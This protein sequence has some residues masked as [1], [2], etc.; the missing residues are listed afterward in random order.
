MSMVTAPFITGALTKLRCEWLG[1]GALG[2]LT[3]WAI[4]LAHP[5]WQFTGPERTMQMNSFFARY[6]F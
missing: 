1:G 4:L 6:V 3:I 5:F 2:V